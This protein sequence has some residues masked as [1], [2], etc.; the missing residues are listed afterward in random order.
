MT[1]A[2]R[3][4]VVYGRMKYSLHIEAILMMEDQIDLFCDE[5]VE[6]INRLAARRE[7]VMKEH[8]IAAIVETAGTGISKKVLGEF[9]LRLEAMKRAGTLKGEPK[10]L[11][12]TDA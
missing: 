6:V 11:A 5:T 2:E 7:V 3:L 12:T 8:V 10:V 4:C 9:E 1:R